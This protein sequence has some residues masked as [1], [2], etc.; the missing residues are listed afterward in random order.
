VVLRKSE[1]KTWG[2]ICLDGQCTHLGDGGCLL[3]D[4]K[5]LGCQ[6]YPLSF[7]PSSRSFLYDSDCP[8][9]P[10]YQRQL[11]DPQSDASSHL[12]RMKKKLFGLE[13]S[14]PVF[15]RVNFQSDSDYFDLKPLEL[16][17]SHSRKNNE[18]R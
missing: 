1:K 9:M 13:K 7:D 12:R 10:E 18:K 5:P 8:L 14:D 11:S 15:L 3:G 2:S 4:R 6:L 16:D 17:A